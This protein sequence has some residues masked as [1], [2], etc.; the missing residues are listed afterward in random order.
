MWAINW[1]HRIRDPKSTMYELVRTKG[2][3]V[4]S[5]SNEVKK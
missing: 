4:I 1:P 2:M 5:M 3:T